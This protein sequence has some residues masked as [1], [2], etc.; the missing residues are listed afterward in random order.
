ML[1]SYKLKKVLLHWFS[2][3]ISALK[4]VSERGYYISEGPA[5]VYSEGLRE[6]VR[7]VPLEKLLTE[8]D[9]PVRYFKA[10]FLGKKT[11]PAY[12]PTVV[13]AIAEERKLDM[14]K[15]SEQIAEN[16]EAY[17]GIRLN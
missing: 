9:G 11:T 2:N 17:F 15:V 1:P 4:E 13:N 5:S 6:V 7:K 8:T 10:P 12:I 16:F 3:P 14:A